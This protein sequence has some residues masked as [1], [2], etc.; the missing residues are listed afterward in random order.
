MQKKD[1]YKI[2]GVSKNASDEEI[3]KAYRKLA[4]Q[5]HPDKPGGD[6]KKFKEINEAYQ[7]LSDKQKRKLYDQYG[8]AEPFGQ[9]F[10][11][12]QAGWDFSNFDFGGSWSGTDFGDLSDLFESFFEGFGARPKR[13][14]YNRG[15][16]LETTLEI[17]LEEAFFGTTKEL[18]IKTFV[19]CDVCNGQ[20]GD[21][22]SGVKTCTTCNGRGEIKE[23]QKTFFGVFSQIKTCP[24]CRG[25]GSIPVKLC[26]KCNGSGKIKGER[27]VKVEIAPGIANNQLIKIKDMGE[28]GE[29]GAGSGDLYVRIKIK[30]HPVF[31]R[32]G[33]DLIVK[34]E[35]NIYD[36]LL[37]KKIEIPTISGGKINIEI[38]EHFNLKEKL[39]IPGE[40]MPKLHSY[41]RGDLLVDFIVKAPKKISGKIKKILEDELNK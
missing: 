40:G 6:E 21:P 19:K 9:G 41:G 14:V 20:G 10:G 18:N 12:S 32:A 17:S 36:L 34:K 25:A 31:D 8:T 24:I 5:Y 11:A 22:S 16:D 13:P 39:K 33:D 3:K 28:A 23:Q 15:A 30:P 2:L 4:H 7:V 26:F 37:G 38:P 29:R 1:Y 35:L 27:K